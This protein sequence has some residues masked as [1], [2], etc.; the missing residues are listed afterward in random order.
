MRAPT[1]LHNNPD[2]GSLDN[3]VS[4]LEGH[5]PFELSRKLGSTLNFNLLVI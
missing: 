2:D 4:V 1:S 5:T 3:P